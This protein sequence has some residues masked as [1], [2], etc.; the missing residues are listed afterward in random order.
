MN[1]LEAEERERNRLVN[2]WRAAAEGKPLENNDDFFRFV[3]DWIA[4]NA[5]YRANASPEASDRSLFRAYCAST[6]LWNKH[7]TLFRER[8]TYAD[9][10][11]TVTEKAVFDCRRCG[12][13]ED[14]YLAALRERDAREFN[15]LN[16][17]G[18]F[19]F[20]MDVVYQIRNNLFHGGKRPYNPRDKELV[21]AA[22]EIVVGLLDPSVSAIPSH[23]RR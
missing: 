18:D 16:R 21:S 1:Q 10:V 22:R 2:T 19:R 12:L 11:L 5:I 20:L 7:K 9:A 14:D 17:R 3:A 15:T 4:Q 13:V 6:P 23:A 8:Q